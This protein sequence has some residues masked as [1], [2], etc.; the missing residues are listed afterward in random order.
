[1]KISGASEAD[2][3]SISGCRDDQTSADVKTSAGAATGAMSLALL[4]VLK[5]YP[6]PPL[7]DLLN[8]MRDALKERKFSQVPQMSTGHYINPTST[9]SF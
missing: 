8:K 3:V 5:T 6:N 9:F 1:M 4:A 7:I 2:I